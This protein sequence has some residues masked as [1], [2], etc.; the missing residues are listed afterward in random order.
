MA[1]TT[2][3]ASYVWQE[4]PV[5]TPVV[6]RPATGGASYL[7]QEPPVV[8]TTVGPTC[9]MNPPVVAPAHGTYNRRGVLL[10]A[11]AAGC[12]HQPRAYAWHEP[13]AVAPVRGTYN[14]RG[15]LRVAGAAGCVQH[16]RAYPGQEPPVAGTAPGPA[17]AAGSPACGRS[18]R[19]W[20][21]SDSRRRL[22]AVAGRP[23]LPCA[24]GR[25]VP[26]ASCA[27]GAGAPSRCC[28]SWPW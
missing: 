19:R 26:P 15:V 9:G 16:P 12:G 21:S 8:G 22:R 1:P 7:W 2:G 3:G 28:T 18:R 23:P 10:V 25:P 27:A 17:P 11:G 14:R 24:G 20:V 13:P 4:P 5:V 6:A